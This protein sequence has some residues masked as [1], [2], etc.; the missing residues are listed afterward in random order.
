MIAGFGVFVIL[1]VLPSLVYY[2]LYKMNL[3][4]RLSY[5][6]D[7]VDIVTLSFSGRNLLA[8]EVY[9]HI[10]FDGSFLNTL[11][12]YGY[13]NLINIVGRNVE[14]DFIDLFMIFGLIGT[15]AMYG[16]FINQLLKGSRLPQAYVYKPYVKFGIW[17]LLILSCLSGHVLNSGM[18]GIMIGALI[19]IQ[20]YPSSQIN[21]K[22]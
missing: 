7:K 16:F 13:N 17:V 12:G 9:E 4:S 10:K 15:L 3:I 1:I 18:A 6:A 20:Y 11:I 14:I 2:V 22:N 21:E 19:A 8:T 5:W